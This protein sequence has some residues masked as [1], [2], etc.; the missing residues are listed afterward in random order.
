MDC[1]SG[2]DV[3][4]VCSDLKS[5]ADRVKALEE[6]QTRLKSDVGAAVTARDASKSTVETL[7]KYVCTSTSMTVCTMLSLMRWMLECLCLFVL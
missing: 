4:D 6:A 7:Q 5:S 3:R 2:C 1:L